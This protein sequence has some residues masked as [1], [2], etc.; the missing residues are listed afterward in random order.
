MNSELQDVPYSAQWLAAYAY[1][2][3]EAVTSPE[4]QKL[5]RALNC[6][7]KDVQRCLRYLI[8]YQNKPEVHP[9]VVVEDKNDAVIEITAQDISLVEDSQSN[10]FV[11]SFKSVETVQ[12]EEKIK[13]AE[14]SEEFKNVMKKYHEQRNM[15]YFSPGQKQ[16]LEVRNQYYDFV[17]SAEKKVDNSL[18][19]NPPT[20]QFVSVWDSL[21]DDIKRQTVVEPWNS[22]ASSNGKH[23]SKF[24]LDKVRRSTY[25]N[26]WKRKSV[27]NSSIQIDSKSS[28][29][30]C[31]ETRDSKQNCV[32]HKPNLRVKST[33]YPK[34]KMIAS[35]KEVPM[36][37]LEDSIEISV[38]QVA[39]S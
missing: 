2:A 20:S 30:S 14:P 21:S 33:Y 36:I 19:L 32:H 11:P 10:Q 12:V 39:K 1:F 8:S 18:R 27:V 37:D 24:Y 26:N 17:P 6:E 23:S 16:K 15:R 4:I 31:D 22:Q 28:W 34:K 25:K 29:D 3:D 38:V 9:E 7:H 35:H 13:P 5:E